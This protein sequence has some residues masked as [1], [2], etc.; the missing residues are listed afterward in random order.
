[1]ALPPPP[2]PERVRVEGAYF[3]LGPSSLAATAPTRP[4]PKYNPDGTRNKPPPPAPYWMR[5]EGASVTPPGAR[6]RA[7]AVCIPG[8]R[9]V[10]VK[11]GRR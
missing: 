5:A 7:L 8:M 1:M 9:A 4:S 3:A 2:P 11:R 10:V 6:T